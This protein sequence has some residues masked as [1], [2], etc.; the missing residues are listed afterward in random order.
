MI[1]V[2]ISTQNKIQVVTLSGDLDA[3]T[4]PVVVEKVQP[5]T[6]VESLI[7]IDMTKVYYMSSAGLRMLLTVYRTISAKGGKVVLIGL[8]TELEDTM[9][10]TGFLDFFEHYASL[11]EGMSAIAAGN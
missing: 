4:T 5:L 10:M 2:N 1:E 11:Q 8:S 7:V 3:S 9:S 6:I